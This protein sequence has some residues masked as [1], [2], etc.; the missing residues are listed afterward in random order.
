MTQSERLNVGLIGCGYQ[1]QWIAEA[2]GKIEGMSLVACVDPDPQAV[3]KT[4]AKVRHKPSAPRTLSSAEALV[5]DREVDAVILATPHQFLHPFAMRAIAAGKHVLSEKP[6]ALNARQASEIEAAA[7]RSPGVFLCGYSFRY[8]EHPAR[9]RDLL[10]SGAIGA[11]QTLSAE[12]ILP[13]LRPGWASEAD[14]G[15]GMLGFFGCH[16]I[17]RVLWYLDNEPVE[18]FAWVGPRNGSGAD[19]ASVFQVRFAGGVTAQINFCAGARGPFDSLQIH[20]TKGHVSLVADTF[21]KYEL[22]VAVAD[23]EPET[24][25]TDIDR[26]AAILGMMVAELTDFAAAI[27]E[28]RAS[29]IPVLEGR[30]VLEVMDA[31]ARSGMSGVPVSV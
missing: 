9:V 25:G 20:G 8:F 29:P 2:I 11:V 15:G 14:A 5:Q 6:I 10:A 26:P 31:I 7:D 22:S 3:A 23:R 28:D 19:L 24:H 13:G 12:M 17:D 18:V 30:K 16:M 21:S 4:A 1:G 27:R